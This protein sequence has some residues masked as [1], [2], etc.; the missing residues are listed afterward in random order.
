MRTD[1][2]GVAYL[3]SDAEVNR[4]FAASVVSGTEYGAAWMIK[5]LIGQLIG[6]DRKARAL[7]MSNPERRALLSACLDGPAETGGLH[8]LGAE[9]FSA[10]WARVKDAILEVEG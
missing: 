9:T 6:A 7:G 1:D 5:S 4:I 2:A 10:M 3:P 8:D